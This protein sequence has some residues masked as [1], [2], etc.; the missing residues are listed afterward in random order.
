MRKIALSITAGAVLALAVPATAATPT[1][2][3]KDNLFKPK[4]VTIKKGGSV[5]WRWKGSNPHNVALKKPGS[6]KVAKRSTIKT[7]GKYSSKFRLRGTWRVLCE[8]HPQDMK[9]KVIVK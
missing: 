8:V 4:S 5:L 6:S 3:V 2:L 7:S 9:M 1:V